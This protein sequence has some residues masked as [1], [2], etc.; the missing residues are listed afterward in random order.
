MCSLFSLCCQARDCITL[1]THNVRAEKRLIR[2]YVEERILTGYILMGKDGDDTWNCLGTTGIDSPDLRKRM[3]SIKELTHKHFWESQVT[4]IPSPTTHEI[5][6]RFFTDFFANHK[7]II[8]HPIPPFVEQVQHHRL[9]RGQLQ[10]SQHNSCSDRD[11]LISL[12]GPPQQSVSDYLI[13]V[14]RQTS[15]SQMYKNHIEMP[16]DQ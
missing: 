11:F 10:Q 6:S 7:S 15:T 3:L 5:F 1:I 4:Y 9:R 14:H 13:E 12:H 2:N 8:W 16:N